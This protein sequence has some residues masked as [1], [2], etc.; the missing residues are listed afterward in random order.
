M[1]IRTKAVTYDPGTPNPLNHTMAP[2]LTLFCYYE[3]LVFL[4]CT[5]ISIT[6]TSLIMNKGYSLFKDVR[7]PWKGWLLG[8]AG[9]LVS[10]L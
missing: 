10:R 1:Q 9:D 6:I 5:V 3:I 4:V 8:G 2:I 7:S